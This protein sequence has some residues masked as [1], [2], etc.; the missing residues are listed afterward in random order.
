MTREQIIEKLRALTRLGNKR[1][2]DS[3]AEAAAAMRKVREWMDKYGVTESELE[4]AERLEDIGHTDT[5]VVIR[6]KSPSYAQVELITLVAKLFECYPML[7]SVH[8]EVI[9]GRNKYETRP[10]F[11]GPYPHHQVAA[12]TFEVL[13]REMERGRKAYKPPGYRGKSLSRIRNGW[14]IGWIDAVTEKVQSMVPADKYAE[15][16]PDTGLVPVDP[17]VQ[18]IDRFKNTRKT[19]SRGVRY[20]PDGQSAGHRAGS[21]VR[22]NPGVSNGAKKLR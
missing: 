15:P 19:S 12:Y 18:Y 5:G 4:Q 1:S 6:A 9:G 8:T 11:I 7:S 20:N 21:R 14:V 3:S 16:D 2:N 13:Y 22:I 17:R 10:R